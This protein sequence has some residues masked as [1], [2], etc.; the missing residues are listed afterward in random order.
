MMSSGNLTDVGALLAEPKVHHRKQLLK[1]TMYFVKGHR[2]LCLHLLRDIT[3]NLN[4]II[5]AHIAV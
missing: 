1:V 2:L 4:P 3:K 5:Q